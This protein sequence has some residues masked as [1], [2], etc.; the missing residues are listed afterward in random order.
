MAAFAVQAAVELGS[1]SW[2]GGRGCEAG[3]PA[4]S[5]NAAVAYVVVVVVA[6]R[7]L[8]KYLCMQIRATKS[9]AKQNETKRNETRSNATQRNEIKR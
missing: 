9:N 7:C 2:N 4:G 6:L 5:W 1:A 8:L 3:E